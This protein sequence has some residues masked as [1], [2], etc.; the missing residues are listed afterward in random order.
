MPRCWRHPIRF[1]RLPRRHAPSGAGESVRLLCAGAGGSW[2]CPRHP[3]GSSGGWPLTPMRFCMAPSG[4]H[5]PTAWCILASWAPCS[6]CSRC[7]F[8][9]D[10]LRICTAQLGDRPVRGFSAGNRSGRTALYA[11]SG[12]LGFCAGRG[13]SGR[14]LRRH[15]RPAGGY[16]RLYGDMQFLLFFIIGIK[17]KYMAAIYALISIAMLFGEQRMYAFAQLGGALAGL[18][19][20]RLAPRRGVSFALSEKWY[21]LR[22]RFYRWKRRRAAASSRSTCVPRAAISA[23]TATAAPSTRTRTTRSTGT[24]VASQKFASSFDDPQPLIRMSS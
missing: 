9:P 21:G 5:S 10:F 19:Y 20:V 6:S 15:L 4:S 22:N 3:S 7:G 12:P 23:L 2:R 14:L 24:S 1:P 13:S 11:C 17:A 8:W 16:R 18:L